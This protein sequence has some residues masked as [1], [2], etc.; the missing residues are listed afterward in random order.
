MRAEAECNNQKLLQLVVTGGVDVGPMRLLQFLDGSL[1]DVKDAANGVVDGL[2]DP[3]I[4]GMS[5]RTTADEVWDRVQNIE[6]LGVEQGGTGGG[7]KVAGKGG[8]GGKAAAADDAVQASIVAA[9]YSQ[10]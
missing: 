5:D 6:I 7:K 4:D 3:A 1:L 2:C 10:H 8:E 9:R